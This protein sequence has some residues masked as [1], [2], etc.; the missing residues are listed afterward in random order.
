M[1]NETFTC[2]S[3]FL[4]ALNPKTPVAPL[5][6]CR[7][8][9]VA[10]FRIRIRIHM[11]LGLPDPDPLVRGMDPEPEIRIL[12]SSRKTLIP[13]VLWLLLDFLFLKMM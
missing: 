2:H 13:T 10:V 7:V 11:F 3:T 6:I 4:Y 12:L 9:L 1:F 8:P 5:S